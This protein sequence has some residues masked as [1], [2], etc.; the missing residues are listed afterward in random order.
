L[1]P[2]GGTDGALLVRAVVEHR[3]AGSAAPAV[4]AA[5]QRS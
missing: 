3:R 1:V 4:A 2:V 5:A